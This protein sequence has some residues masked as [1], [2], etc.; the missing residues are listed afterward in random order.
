M[1]ITLTYA[2]I[3]PWALKLCA[4]I[5]EK[6]LRKKYLK[7]QRIKSSMNLC[8]NIARHLTLRYFRFIKKDQICFH[9]GFNLHLHPISKW[10]LMFVFFVIDSDVF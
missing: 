9:A 1:A 3:P 2:G 4:Q 8:I 7:S 5:N 10:R 6:Q